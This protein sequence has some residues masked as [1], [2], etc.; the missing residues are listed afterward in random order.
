MASPHLVPAAVAAGILAVGA[1]AGGAFIGKGVENAR[2]GARN[3]T[4]RGVS[5]RVVK[6]DLAV[7][8][9]KFA[10]AGDDL[11]LVQAD[12]DADLTATRRFLAQRGFAAAEI[13][14]GRFEVTD[15][16][17]REYQPSEIRARYRVAQTVIVRTPN[18]DRVQSTSR[19]LA[20]EA[21]QGPAMARMV[22]K[23]GVNIHMWPPEILDKLEAAWKEVA[24]EEAAKNPTFKKVY[25]SYT[26]FRDEYAIWRERGYLN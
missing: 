18:V 16:Y 9:L 7:L 20:H 24:E 26:K 3:V 8:A 10:A 25:A 11:A 5:E 1:A 15:Q 23:H 6:A 4:V 14:L 13:D 12:V 17:A 22:E 19:A 2:V 21:V